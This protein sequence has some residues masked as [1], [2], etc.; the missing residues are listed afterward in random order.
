MTNTALPTVAGSRANIRGFKGGDY[1]GRQSAARVGSAA[2][3]WMVLPSQE[4]AAQTDP[5]VGTWVLNVAKSK[6]D[7]GPPP[8]SST[9]TIVAAG[10]GY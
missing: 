2:G 1:E 8:K 10:Q 6:Y 5:S 9:V 3:V 7:P 4:A